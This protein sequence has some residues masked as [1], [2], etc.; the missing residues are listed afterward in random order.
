MEAAMPFVF[1]TPSDSRAYTG[2]VVFML[3]TVGHVKIHSGKQL[4]TLHNLND[5]TQEVAAYLKGT[6][7]RLLRGSKVLV[8]GALHKQEQASGGHTLEIEKVLV[9]EPQSLIQQFWG[10]LWAPLPTQQQT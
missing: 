6:H 8:S 10:S 5:Q 9:N 7:P 2:K 4:L 1:I 3:A